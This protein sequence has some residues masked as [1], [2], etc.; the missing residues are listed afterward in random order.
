MK[1]RTKFRSIK[2][3]IIGSTLLVLVAGGAAFAV[4]QS[5]QNTLTGNTISTAT[6][7][8]QISK[9]GTS[10]S[11]TSVGFD[12][13]DI[14]PGGA[15]MPITGQPFYLKNGG[16]TPLSLKF[17]VNGTPTNP[18]NIDLSKVSII[19][20][21]VASGTSPQTFSLQ[22]LIAAN[23]TGGLPISINNL[24]PGETQLY[25]LQVSMA[26]DALNASSGSLTNVDFA[27]SG[28]AQSL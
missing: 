10:F 26:A 25:K 6:A 9:D 13:S 1:K 21:T 22:S 23:S 8:L 16:G 4:L 28:I 15:A 17:S 5:Q 20:T 7:N 11:E 3:A 2:R 24:N 19:L 27:F 14:V 12:F 18:D